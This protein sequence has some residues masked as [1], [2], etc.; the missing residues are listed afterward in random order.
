[1]PNV[2]NRQGFE[3]EVQCCLKEMEIRLCNKDTSLLTVPLPDFVVT[4]CQN[5][6]DKGQNKIEQC[7]SL[8]NLDGFK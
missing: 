1:M 5:K 3:E 6:Q 2:F 7:V 4:W 8:N